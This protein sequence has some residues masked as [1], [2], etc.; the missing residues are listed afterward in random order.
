MEALP[1]HDL[2]L[3]CIEIK[4]HATTVNI[5][6]IFTVLHLKKLKLKTSKP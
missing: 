5:N 1:Y 3:Q 6:Y 4:T 2:Q